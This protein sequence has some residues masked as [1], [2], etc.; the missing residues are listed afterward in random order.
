MVR[1]LPQPGPDN[2]HTSGYRVFRGKYTEEVRANRPEPPKNYGKCRST[3][4]VGRKAVPTTLEPSNT[5][6]DQDRTESARV[7]DV[8]STERGRTKYEVI[9]RFGGE[10]FFEANSHPA[11]RLFALWSG[12]SSTKSRTVVQC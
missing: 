3:G 1:Y 11:A 4:G 2:P 12:A 6:G 9:W 5:D 10:L 7:C 8:R